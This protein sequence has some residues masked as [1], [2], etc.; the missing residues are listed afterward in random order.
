MLNSMSQE[1]IFAYKFDQAA[2]IHLET[3]ATGILSTATILPGERPP[4]GNVVN[5]GVLASN[6]QHLFSFRIDPAVDGHENSVVQ[7]DSVAMPYDPVNPPKNNPYGVGY[8]VD[9]KTISTSGWADA[10][11]EKARVFKVNFSLAYSELCSTQLRV[12]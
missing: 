9:K 12:F 5:P 11:P 4:Y 8:T 2:A 1:Y 6:H 3:R 10:A 7:E